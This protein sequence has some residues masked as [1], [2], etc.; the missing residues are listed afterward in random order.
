MMREVNGL[1]GGYRGLCASL[2][3][4]A[5]CALLLAGPGVALAVDYDSPAE[6][7]LNR[8]ASKLSSSELS[9]LHGAHTGFRWNSGD[10]STEYWRPQGI[11]GYIESGR[12]FLIV[13]WAGQAAG[14]Y[15]DSL[16]VRIT[17]VDVTSMNNIRYRH[18]LL[19]DSRGRVFAKMHAGG[20]HSQSGTLHVTDSRYSQGWIRTFNL[21]RMEDLNGGSF[22]GYRYILRE[23]GA[24]KVPTKPSF[25]AY[26]WSRSQFVVGTFTDKSAHNVSGGESKASGAKLAWYAYPGWAQYASVRS[27]FYPQ[28]QGAV[29]EDNYLWTS[30]SYGRSNPS[31]LHVDCYRPGDST[32]YTRRWTYPPGLEDMHRALTSDN[33]WMLTEFGPHEGS[34]NNRIVFAT[35][36]DRL[37]PSGDC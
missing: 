36:H 6:L 16:G 22:M 12:K 32:G 15:D 31:H 23:S 3:A 4:A 18:V 21:N 24:Y 7:N 13:S 30:H 19:L 20:I 34:G 2:A 10:N 29:S 9:P 33:I 5:C 1:G 11:T 25:L 8:T 26:D 35:D 17:V 37:K 27:N 14:N 28:M